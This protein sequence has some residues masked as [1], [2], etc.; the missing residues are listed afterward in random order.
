MVSVIA[1]NELV[2]M[3]PD[4]AFLALESG[5]VMLPQSPERR[6]LL[7]LQA[8]GR[9]LRAAHD[10]A[11]AKDLK[12]ITEE[13]EDFDASFGEQQKWDDYMLKNRENRGIS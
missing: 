11:L 4:E 13:R 7:A 6:E 8:A 2:T 9:K 5:R 3:P 1:G 10:R 12:R